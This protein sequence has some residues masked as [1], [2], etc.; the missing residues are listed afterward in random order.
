MK[1]ETNHEF[2]EFFLTEDELFNLQFTNLPSN[3]EDSFGNAKFYTG[4]ATSPLWHVVE[5]MKIEKNRRESAKRF[6]SPRLRRSPLSQ[7]V[8]QQ[9]RQYETEP[10]RIFWELQLSSALWFGRLVRISR[11][12]ER[13]KIDSGDNLILVRNLSIRPIGEGPQTGTVEKDR[14]PKCLYH[15]VDGNHRLLVYAMYIA[16]NLMK[17]NPVRVIHAKSWQHSEHRVFYNKAGIKWYDWK[18]QDLECSGMIHDPCRMERRL[19]EDEEERELFFERIKLPVKFRKK[20]AYF[21]SD[22]TNSTQSRYAIHNDRISNV[23]ARP[24]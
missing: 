15:I 7:S 19:I 24:F 20:S 14:S 4:L 9:H 10:T 21:I 18:S 2:T 1:E 6:E 23:T 3:P 16:C 11:N 17:Y 12:F 8:V 13:K 22:S 5:Q